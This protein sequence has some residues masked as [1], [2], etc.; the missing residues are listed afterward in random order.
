V[1][2]HVQRDQLRDGVAQRVSLVVAVDGA[3]PSRNA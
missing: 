3:F 2:D 1:A